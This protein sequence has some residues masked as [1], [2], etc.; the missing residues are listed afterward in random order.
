MNE[1]D[2]DLMAVATQAAV[3]AAQRV[4]T[5]AITRPASVASYD[6][7][8]ATALVVVDG[9]D[10]ATLVDVALGVPLHSN[11]RVFVQFMPPSG[12]QVIGMIG[13]ARA[14]A[15]RW[16][17]GSALAV[18]SGVLAALPLGTATAE[19]PGEDW[20]LASGS[21]G[22][23]PAVP[24]WYWV[25]ARVTFPANATG[26]RRVSV[27]KNGAEELV[28]NYPPSTPEA[29][30]LGASGAIYATPG[31]TIAVTARQNSG[32]SLSLNTHRLSLAFIGA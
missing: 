7:E 32:T 22:I 5:R 11:D 1:Q 3:E 30:I 14:V 25:E 10:E 6:G 9:D 19:T 13:L 20:T 2:L 15:G 29:V 18:A 4:L 27:S 12:A 24:G 31:D 16:D 21:L 26:G 23:T 17:S 8:N 28:G